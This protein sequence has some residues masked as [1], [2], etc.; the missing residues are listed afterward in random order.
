MRRLFP[1]LLLVLFAFVAACGEDKTV[2]GPASVAGSY[3]LDTV[4]GAPLPAVVAQLGTSKVE[5][6]QGTLSLNSDDTFSGNLETRTTSGS[7]VTTDQ[8]P[9]NGTYTVAGNVMTFNFSDGSTTTGAFADNRVT[10]IEPDLD[11][12]LV[13]EK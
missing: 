13:F 5:V 6:T 11:L 1:L 7:S 2:T 12:T 8:N 3:H 10:V 9:V 4:N